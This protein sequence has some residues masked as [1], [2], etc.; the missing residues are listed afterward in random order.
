M[1]ICTSQC[2]V[3]CGVLAYTGLYFSRKRCEKIAGRLA[4]HGKENMLII[5]GVIFMCFPLL[6]GTGITVLINRKDA[7]ISADLWETYLYGFLCCIGIFEIG[8]LAGVFL[9]QTVTMCGKI[10]IGLFAAVSILAGVSIFV[11]RRKVLSAVGIRVKKR[12]PV[13]SVHGAQDKMCRTGLAGVVFCGLL[14]GQVVYICT[15]PMLQTAGDITL[16]TVNSFL[17]S[18]GIYKVSPLTGKA[19]GGAPLRYEILCLPTVYTF[20]CKWTGISAQQIVCNVIPLLTLCV[21]YMVYYLLSGTLF[22]KDKG[23]S[24][25]RVW[26]LVM[27]ALIFFLSEASVYMDGYGILHGGH[28]GTTIRNCILMP[29]MLYAAL[30]KKWLLSVLCILAEMCIVWTFWGLGTCVVVLVG[31]CM[32]DLILKKSHLDKLFSGLSSKE[33]NSR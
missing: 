7:D 11:K 21:T 26:F 15:V 29:L 6:P 2:C 31:V 13:D 27:A 18:D 4:I 8:H 3:H 28:L 32:M 9:D 17:F 10:T 14:I 30:E 25:K 22:G 24:E 5:L 16:E 23:S 20:L 19:F 33:E 12:R 1:R